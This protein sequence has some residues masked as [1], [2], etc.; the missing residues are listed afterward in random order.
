MDIYQEVTLQIRDAVKEDLF[1]SDQGF[2]EETQKNVVK[3]LKDSFNKRYEEVGKILMED[4]LIFNPDTG[5][6]F[7]TPI[8]TLPLFAGIRWRAI[9]PG[10]IYLN[11]DINN[12]YV[13]YTEKGIFHKVN[14]ITLFIDFMKRNSLFVLTVI[15]AV[16]LLVYSLIK[17][18]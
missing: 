18:G 17:G 7:G 9:I 11:Y 1:D 16:Y 12:K 8:F 10:I 5:N 6:T 14:D 3:I 15:L 4:V 2:D 13:G